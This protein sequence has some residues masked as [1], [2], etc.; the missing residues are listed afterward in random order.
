[1]DAS[2][3]AVRQ[4]LSGEHHEI[5]HLA[6]ELATT[7]P[8]TAGPLLDNLHALL[9][10]HFAH[11][12]YPGGLYDALGATGPAVREDLR[13]LVDQHFL[14]VSKLQSLRERVR[15]PDEVALPAFA[16][17]LAEFATLLNSHEQRELEM[18]GRLS[19]P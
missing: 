15:R 9:L 3:A 8:A 19:A 12:E 14:I 16:A 4:E 11:E 1:M 6:A 10:R 18:V 5:H 17:D 13:V 7:T 2:L